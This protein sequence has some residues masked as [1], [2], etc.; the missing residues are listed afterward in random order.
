MIDFKKIFGKNIPEE[1]KFSDEDSE[2][3]S[4][5]ATCVILLEIA[6]ADNEFLEIERKNIIKIMKAEFN[7]SEKDSTE[8]I[9]ISEKKIDESIDIWQFTNLINQN[10]TKE[11]KMKI[12][13]NAWKIIYSDDRLDAYEDHLIHKISNLLRLNHKELIETKLKVSENEKRD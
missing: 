6:N 5:I 3:K 7:L 13:E 4:Q 10:S 12:L 11:E 9:K 8:L 2:R 1:E